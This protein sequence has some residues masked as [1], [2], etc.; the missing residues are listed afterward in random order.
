MRTRARA[1]DLGVE[2]SGTTGEHNA[3][4]DVPGVRGAALDAARGGPIAEGNVGGGTGMVCFRFKG[5][6]G[7][8]SRR[9]G[10][11]T[12]GVIVQANFGLR[13]QLVMGGVPVG[14][15]LPEAPASASE[16]GSILV[17]IAT[18]APLLPHQLK[19]VARRAPLGLARTGGAAG[20]GSGDIMLAFSTA[21]P[22]AARAEPGAR[23][24]MLA[25]KELTPLFEA[26]IG[27]TEEAILNAL[28]AADT[29]TGLAGR[30]IEALPHA[31]VRAILA[32][33]RPRS[34][35]S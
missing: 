25:N 30:T 6:T 29:M 14:R 7:T 4:T 10:E 33:Y 1:R 2:L 15:E 20:N 32:R 24:E 11:Y 35:E 19:R 34:D 3:I 9:C 17:V 23:V 16:T 18:D 8:A 21:N 26:T 27:A 22:G 5:G 12:V 31:R 13:R 28:V